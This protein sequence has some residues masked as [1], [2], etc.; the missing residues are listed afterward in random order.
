[1]S[2]GTD[3]RRGYRTSMDRRQPFDRNETS[4]SDRT[5]IPG[6]GLPVKGAANHG[7][8]AVRTKHDVGSRG[9]ATF[10]QELGTC[11]SVLRAKHP[12]PEMNQIR[13]DAQGSICQD[14]L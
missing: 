5:G 12:G 3:P 4:P 6:S 10:E 7:V 14:A 1:M 9:R 13:L 2:F 11:V 8:D